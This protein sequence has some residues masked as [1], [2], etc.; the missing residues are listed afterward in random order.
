M[1][2]EI[3]EALE[4]RRFYG[5][6]ISVNA[7]AE[8]EL[9]GIGTMEVWASTEELDHFNE[10]VKSFA[11]KDSIALSKKTGKWPPFLVSHM[12]AL[13][14]GDVPVIGRVVSAEEVP[15]KGT[16]AVVAFAPAD[17]Q[18]LATRWLKAFAGGWITDV[19]VGFMAKEIE[20]EAGEPLTHTKSLWLELSAA[21]VG[22]AS[23]ANAI[24]VTQKSLDGAPFEVVELMQDLLELE[25]LNR[26]AAGLFTTKAV[27]PFKGFSKADDG[28]SWQWNA[29]A[30]NAVLGDPPDWARLKSV[31]TWWDREADPENAATPEER[32]AYKLPHHKVV[33]DGIKTVFRG[34]VAAMGALLGAR[35]GVDIPESDRRGVYNHLS[36][37]YKEFEREAPEFRTY[38]ADEFLKATHAAGIGYTA[39]ELELKQPPT[40]NVP[41]EDAE[42]VG[43][44]SED[45][46][47]FFLQLVPKD[48]EYV[49]GSLREIPLK[50]DEP[51]V[52]A[53]V[54]KPAADGEE[55]RDVITFLRFPKADGWSENGVR[56]WVAEVNLET[57]LADAMGDGERSQHEDDDK[58]KKSAD[59][60]ALE[61]TVKTLGEQVGAL[62][63][64]VTALDSIKDATLTLASRLATYLDQVKS[65]AAPAATSEPGVSVLPE[66]ASGKLDEIHK[67]LNETIE[68]GSRLVSQS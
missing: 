51:R 18:P 12:F 63:A 58:D 54:G 19:S 34:V 36:R 22:A 38:T 42:G 62:T 57:M 23:G 43:D 9:G 46:D 39:D 66:D 48:T 32:G 2:V 52:F 60:V 1:P 3:L 68:A 29:T 4:A 55:G 17:V 49:A 67:D 31:H 59:V 21:A 44:I 37:H 24:S 45:E 14:N 50:K 26:K 61:A 5:K 56:E 33:G 47:N 53:T 11:F 20:R 15:G 41:A 6:V 40:T 7:E 16:K 27:V 8:N 64:Q 65:V 35:G 25:Q 28:L 13:A 30:A 10:V